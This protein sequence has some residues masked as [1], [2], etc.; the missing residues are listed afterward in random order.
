MVLYIYPFVA[1][2]RHGECLHRVKKEILIYIYI[3]YT[4]LKR[5][6]LLLFNLTEFAL[7]MN[8][9]RSC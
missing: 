1:K 4:N 8:S 9:S 3:L 2:K 6:I 7:F 5:A